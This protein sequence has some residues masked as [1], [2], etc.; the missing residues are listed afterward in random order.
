[1]PLKTLAVAIYMFISR[2][3]INK[4][5]W[6]SPEAPGKLKMLWFSPSSG[7]TVRQHGGPFLILYAGG[8]NHLVELDV[9][10]LQ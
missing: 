1:M 8:V 4:L 7:A 3:V 2:Y 6:V 5:G 10:T 9:L